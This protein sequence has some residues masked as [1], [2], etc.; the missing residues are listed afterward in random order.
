MEATDQI[1]ALEG[2]TVS[3]GRLNVYNAVQNVAA[4]TGFVEGTVTNNG[5]QPLAALIQVIDSVIETTADNDGQYSLR[6]ESGQSYNL[7]ASFFGY[8]PE[9]TTV[10]IIENQTLTRNFVLQSTTNGTIEGY[11][12]DEENNLPIPGAEIRVLNTPLE[13]TAS[14]SEGFYQISLPGNQ[15]YE[16]QVS[17]D[18]HLPLTE[19]V[20]IPSDQIAAHDFILPSVEISV[21]PAALNE[22]LISGQ[23]SSQILNLVNNSAGSLNFSVSVID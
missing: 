14:N 21:S 18:H 22:A 5:G 3:G 20:F 12:R 15:D 11:V 13:P 7:E 1:S 4:P 17:A 23:T 19:P 9:T 8:I 10:T 16:F 6:L 2:I